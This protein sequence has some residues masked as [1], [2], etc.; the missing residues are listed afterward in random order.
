MAEFGQALKN[1]AKD[2][3]GAF[4]QI[5]Q[6]LAGVAGGLIGGRARRREQREARKELPPREAWGRGKEVGIDGYSVF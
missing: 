4:G 6:G 2:D 5:A 1:T 3:P